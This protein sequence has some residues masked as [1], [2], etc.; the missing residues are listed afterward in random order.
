MSITLIFN[1]GF[2]VVPGTGQRRKVTAHLACPKT[3]TINGDA[4]NDLAKEL[5][6]AFNVDFISELDLNPRS[7][8]IRHLSQCLAINY[9][10]FKKVV[11]FMG[12]R[13]EGD[14]QGARPQHMLEAHDRAKATSDNQ[15]RLEAYKDFHGKNYNPEHDADYLNGIVQQFAATLAANETKI[16]VAGYKLT[17]EIESGGISLFLDGKPPQSQLVDGMRIEFLVNEG[18][19]IPHFNRLNPAVV[20]NPHVLEQPPT[21]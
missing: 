1:G 12:G 5:T 3:V 19:E 15:E 20:N 6:T 21:K 8:P 16:W 17:V 18:C 7:L 4:E 2:F 11:S 9:R 13:V 14:L 10:D